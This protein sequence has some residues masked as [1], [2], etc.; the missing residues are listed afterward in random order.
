MHLGEAKIAGGGYYCFV[1]YGIFTREDIQPNEFLLEYGGELISVD[2]AM[3]LENIYKKK[4]LGCF[5][6]Y[7][8]HQA[9]EMR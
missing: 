7:I 2:E 3:K 8:Q 1:E 6:Y 5:M 4:N 9:K